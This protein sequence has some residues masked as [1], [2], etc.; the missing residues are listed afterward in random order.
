M[1]M[2]CIDCSRQLKE[3]LKKGL[4]SEEQLGKIFD[5]LNQSGH[6]AHTHI[7]ES[8]QH[9]VKKTFNPIMVD[10]YIGALLIL[11]AFG[12]FLGSQWDALGPGGILI[13]SS[14]YALLFGYLGHF[15]Y[16]REK[17]PVA[18]GL[19]FTCCI[20]MV[21]LIVYSLQ[22]LIGIWPK[23]APGTYHDYYVWINGSWIIIELATIA[24]AFTA[25]RKI[26]FSFL[27]M[28]AAI[29]FWFLSMDLAE[30]V[31]SSHRLTW[32]MRSWVS[33]VIGL[34]ILVI[35]LASD[36]ISEGIDYVFWIYLA[37]LLS[38]WG[39]LTSLPIHNEF[40]K[41]IYCL[42]NVGLIGTSL[43][44]QRKSF[45]V[46]G[47][48]GLFGYL[49]HLAW[50]VFKDSMLF[51]VALAFLGVMMILGTVLYQKNYSRLRIFF[52]SNK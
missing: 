13:V 43:K 46:F 32:E 27:I 19:L 34:L 33:V 25:L 9:E 16:F 7:V 51:P 5:E 35:G 23:S 30:I 2:L 31:I 24:A 49:G 36:K 29:A 3:C 6:G 21:P 15:I 14:C 37:G 50:T 10:Y 4:L 52:G 41:F 47:A 40:G 42:I 44:L 11:S 17:Y 48:F 22:A 8:S 20:G 39:G 38:F 1:N 18:G 26:K 45:A 12:W 28:P